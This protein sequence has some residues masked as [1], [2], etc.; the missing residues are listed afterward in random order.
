M[1]ERGEF[2]STKVKNTK[3]VKADNSFYGI[4]TIHHILIIGINC[5]M[6]YYASNLMQSR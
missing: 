4:I 5:T 3:T 2:V 6:C 1:M